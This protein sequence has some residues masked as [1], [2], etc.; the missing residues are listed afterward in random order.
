MRMKHGFLI[1]IPK[2]YNLHYGETLQ[3]SERLASHNHVCDTSTKY[4]SLSLEKKSFT[5]QYRTTNATGFRRH[6]L[7]EEQ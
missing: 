4:F 1:F 6:F 2:S 7:D 3:Q 5:S